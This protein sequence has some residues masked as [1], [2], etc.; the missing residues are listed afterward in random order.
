MVQRS[1]LLAVWCAASLA[2]STV[3]AAPDQ[4]HVFA[5]GMISAAAGV[6]CLAFMPD[7]KTVFFHQEP[8]SLG[9]I[10]VAHKVK[11]RWSMPAIASFSGT[12]HDHDPAVA[13]DG[14]FVVFASNRPD[15]P[16]GTPLRGGHLWRVNRVGNGWSAPIRLPDVVN[17]G[18]HI[19]APSV[20]AN[21]DLYFQSNDNPSHEYHLFHAARHGGAYQ[22]PVP[23]TL[24]PESMHELDPSIAPDQSFIVFDAGHAGS[25]QPDR[26]YIAFRDGHGWGKAIDLG[27]AIDAYQPWGAHIGP[28]GTT[29]YFSGIYTTRTD[30]PRTLPQAQQD[31]ARIR[32]W[33]NGTTRIFSVSLKPWLVAHRT[34]QAVLRSKAS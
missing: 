21:G 34:Q 2:C 29:L 19:F 15:V 28:D 32:T 3:I 17:F 18:S 24:M 16:G 20:A 7:S 22:K 6:D 10:M 25:D 13:P 1:I 30:W 9:M 4:P 33:D 12:W 27:D 14:S 26:L 23:L 5:P 31:L 8:W 11:N